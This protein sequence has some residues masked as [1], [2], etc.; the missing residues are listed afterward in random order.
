MLTSNR[1]DG[2]W[3]GVPAGFRAGE[4][5]AVTGGTAAATVRGP[6]VVVN[7]SWQERTVSPT[8]EAR[9]MNAAVRAKGIL[10]ERTLRTRIITGNVNP[11][12]PCPSRH[13]A[14]RKTATDKQ[15]YRDSSYLSYVGFSTS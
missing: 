8:G 4:A 1:A 15:A 13:E 2:G 7:S 3:P 6:G 9:T 11:P 12:P 10:Y 14:S 5:L